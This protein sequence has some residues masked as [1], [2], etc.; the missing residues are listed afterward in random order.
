MA[1]L[2]W[3]LLTDNIAVWGVQGMHQVSAVDCMRFIFFA[4]FCARVC[5]FLLFRIHTMAILGDCPQ[6][7]STVN[8]ANQVLHSVCDKIGRGGGGGA[9]ASGEDDNEDDD[10]AAPQQHN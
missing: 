6:L 5:V 1:L 10:D 7:D 4:F 9:R 2:A 3:A 8:S